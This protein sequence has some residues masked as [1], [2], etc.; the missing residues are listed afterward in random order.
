MSE[1]FSPVPKADIERLKRAIRERVIKPFQ[2]GAKRRH[3]LQDAARRR[4][5]DSPGCWCEPRQDDE[6]PTL[7]I[8]NDQP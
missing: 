6:E 5:V 3:E 7:W 2:A 4:H 8:H 1:K